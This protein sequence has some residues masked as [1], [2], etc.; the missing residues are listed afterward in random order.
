MKRSNAA[1]SPSV[2]SVVQRLAVPGLLLLAVHLAPAAAGA[3]DLVDG[4]ALSAGAFNVLNGDRSAEAGFELRL[5][6]LWEGIAERPWVVR[7]AVGAMATS[8]EALYGYAGFR[9][10]I[11]LGARWLLTPQ[12]AA[13][14]YDRGDEKELGGSVQFRSGLELAYRL[15]PEHSVG[16]VFYHL[17]NAGL[18]RPNPGSESLVVFWAWR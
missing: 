10:E 11:P 14:Y 16:A 15:N 18:E 4:L 17:S 6:P 1:V 7:P 5:R 13:G 2:R 12:S 8:G 9:L 3:E